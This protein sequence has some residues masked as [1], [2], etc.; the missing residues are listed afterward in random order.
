MYVTGYD[1]ASTDR[2][3]GGV[4]V[5]IKREERDQEIAVTVPVGEE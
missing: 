4:H 2:V 5:K 3:V 1:N